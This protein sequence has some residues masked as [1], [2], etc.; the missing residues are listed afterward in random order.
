MH[1]G[2]CVGGAGKGWGESDIQLSLFIGDVALVFL[3][4]GV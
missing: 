2:E 3:T 1:V 4:S